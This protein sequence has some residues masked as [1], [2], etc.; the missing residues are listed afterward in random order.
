MIFVFLY[1][2]FFLLY[3]HIFWLICSKFTLKCICIN[4]N[5]YSF[6]E[7][8]LL[9]VEDLTCIIDYCTI[10]VGSGKLKLISIHT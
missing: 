10:K 5:F 6:M 3:L 9:L 8:I 4:Y 7:T 1:K 2:Y